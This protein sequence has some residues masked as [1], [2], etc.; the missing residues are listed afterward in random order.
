MLQILIAAA[1]V[2]DYFPID[3]GYSWTYEATAGEKKVEIVKSVTGKE[4]VGDADCFIVEDRGMGG[5]FRKLYL[6][7][8]KDGLQVL[9]MRR[10][11]TKP[12]PWLKFPF[13]KGVRWVHQLASPESKDKA[14]LEFVVEDEEEIVVPAGTYKARRV[15]MFGAED[16]KDKQIDVTMWYAPN[17]GEVKRLTKRIRGDKVE[18]GTMKLLKFTKGK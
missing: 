16:G 17:V 12:F 15:R 11:I 6:Q 13:E 4:K 14:S 1:L 18:E 7:K 8:D 2:Q 5:D 10:E 3:E 9:K